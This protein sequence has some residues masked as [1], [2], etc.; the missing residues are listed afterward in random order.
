MIRPTDAGKAIPI[1]N[2]N[3]QHTR[4]GKEFPQ[5]NRAHQ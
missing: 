1:Q 2:K 4:N 5:Y 3:S